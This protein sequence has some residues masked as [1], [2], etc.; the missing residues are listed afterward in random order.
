MGITPE[1]AQAAGLSQEEID[2]INEVDDQAEEGTD[3]ATEEVT[4]EENNDASNEPGSD[5]KDEE[6]D[7]D[8][9]DD[10]GESAD[11]TDETEEQETGSVTEPAPPADDLF[12][13]IEVPVVA[14]V[15]KLSGELLPEFAQATEQVYDAADA[16]LE[17]IEA[18]FDSGD[19]DEAAKRAEIRKVERERDAEIRKISAASQN[20]EIGAQKWQAEQEAFFKT[21]A[22]YAE[23]QMFGM[24][25]AEV[26][27]IANL[28]ESAGKSGIE[29]LEAAR[30]SVDRQIEALYVKRYG[31][32]PEQGQK[33][34]TESKPKA[35]RPD[36]Q[37][38]GGV[39]AAAAPDTGNDRW[40]QLDKL[41]G[42]AYETALSRLSEADQAAY[43]AGR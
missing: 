9:G 32:A 23:P 18:K 8:D 33:K 14:F 28:P 37:T 16:K 7:G 6:S 17:E 43:L 12:A 1:E 34:Q 24:L 19:L 4:D 38:L 15:P 29:V 20:A 41:T 3:E 30:R 40:A 10:D 13:G 36:V 21:H 5:D 27:R 31:K 2:A 11:D 26:I 39:P 42:M 35:R 22:E 25:N